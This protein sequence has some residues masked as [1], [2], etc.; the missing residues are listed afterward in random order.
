MMATGN[1]IAGL[2]VLG[3]RAA[4]R[5]SGSAGRMIGMFE[6]GGVARGTAA[7]AAAL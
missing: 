2:G 3:S 4:D 7:G 6:R 1:A 5:S